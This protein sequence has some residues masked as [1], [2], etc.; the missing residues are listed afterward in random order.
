MKIEADSVQQVFAVF[1]HEFRGPYNSVYL[2]FGTDFEVAIQRHLLQISGHANREIR[3]AFIVV[4]VLLFVHFPRR[5]LSTE[6]EISCKSLFADFY[7]A[8]YFSHCKRHFSRNKEEL[9]NWFS[10][11]VVGGFS[12]V[13]LTKNYCVMM[14]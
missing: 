1:W 9:S 6:K 2:C 3:T 5:W 8:E 11:R 7:F 10:P 13:T 14:C 12:R 4:P